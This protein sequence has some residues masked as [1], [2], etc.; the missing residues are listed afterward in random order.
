M[1]HLVLVSGGMDSA[2]VLAMAAQQRSC[3]DVLAL[4]IRYGSTHQKTEMRAAQ[5]VCKAIGVEQYVITLPNDIFVGGSSALLGEIPIPV[6]EYHDIDKESPSATVVPFRNGVF[7][8]I[9]VAMAEAH[10]FDK[11]WY[12]NHAN[13]ATGFAYPDCTP[14]FMGAMTS[15]AYIG[16]HRKVRL[17][18]PFQWMKK[19]DIVREAVIRFVP[20]GL[21]W[22]CYRGKEVHCG[23]CP[24]CTERINAFRMA[25]YIDP[26]KYAI[27][28][29]WPAICREYPHG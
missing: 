17:A 29:Q 23:S 27:E 20:L 22:S 15:A 10:G 8:S 4:S 13:D 5:K 24:T 16:T 18:T 25:C 2:T 3:E 6:G 7:L 12:A 21:T 14:E 9:A 19:S 26:V 1:K 11:V 28:V